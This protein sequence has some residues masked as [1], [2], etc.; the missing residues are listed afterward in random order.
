[1][2]RL[3]SLVRLALVVFA[4]TTLG[5]CQST[6]LVGLV[7]SNA[8]P[9]MSVPVANAIAG[10]MVS[11]FL[12]QIGPGTTTIALKQD[13]S[14]FGQAL[15]TALKNSGYAVVTD[16]K[17]DDKARPIALAYVVEPFEGNI[18]VRLSTR[19]I[20]IGRAYAATPTGTTPASPLSVIRRG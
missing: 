20:D 7:A 10:D 8:P 5:A 2:R 6:R 1:M 14:P 19:T 3:P 4:I 16:Q 9:E 11:R 18:L 13:N 17:T 15:E 12:E